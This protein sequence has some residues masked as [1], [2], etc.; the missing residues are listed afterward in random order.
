MVK[1]FLDQGAGKGRPRDPFGNPIGEVTLE[2][3]RDR[4]PSPDDPNPRAR[5]ARLRRAVRLPWTTP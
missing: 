1:Q 3:S 4:A 2:V 5:S